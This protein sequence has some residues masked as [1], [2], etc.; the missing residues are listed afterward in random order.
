MS[1]AHSGLPARP[2]R[3]E[4][5][6]GMVTAELAL[7][8]PVVVLMLVALLLGG[9]AMSAQ[10]L[11]ENAARTGA[12]ALAVGQSPAEITARVQELAGP[13]AQVDFLT[14][15]DIVTCR[16]TRQLPSLLGWAGLQAQAE[17]SLQTE[18]SYQ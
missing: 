16:V 17:L 14:A 6:A 10:V 15:G 12:R 2:G 1:A 18:T 8:L 5:E 3:E 9:G 4:N 7:T 11:V 13:G